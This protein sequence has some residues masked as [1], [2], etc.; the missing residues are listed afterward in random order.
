MVI[1]TTNAL[2]SADDRRQA[3]RVEFESEDEL[4][5]YDRLMMVEA[6]ELEEEILDQLCHGD[7]ESQALELSNSSPSGSTLLWRSPT[8]IADTDSEADYFARKEDTQKTM[9]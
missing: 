6:D 5:E 1:R 8:R 2:S 7:D 9:D 4:D 3:N